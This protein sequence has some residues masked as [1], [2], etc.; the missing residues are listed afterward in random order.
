MTI[1]SLRKARIQDE[2]LTIPLNVPTDAVM[3]IAVAWIQRLSS[4]LAPPE[5]ELK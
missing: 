4:D 2:K 5:K 3:R 1:D